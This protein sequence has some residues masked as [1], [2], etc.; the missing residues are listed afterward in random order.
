[1]KKIIMWTWPSVYDSNN[2]FSRVQSFFYQLQRVINSAHP[3]LE[4]CERMYRVFMMLVHPEGGDDKSSH[5]KLYYYHC[6]FLIQRGTLNLVISFKKISM[7][8][9]VP[10]KKSLIKWSCKRQKLWKRKLQEEKKDAHFERFKLLH[11]TKVPGVPSFSR[12]I[13][14]IDCE[15]ECMDFNG[16]RHSVGKYD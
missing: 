15:R 6:L 3:K 2:T 1:M 8:L 7:A 12:A 9:A 11:F 13:I 5:T 10:S 4:L 14:L 16:R